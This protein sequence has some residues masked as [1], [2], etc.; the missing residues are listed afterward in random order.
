MTYRFIDRHKDRWPVRLLCAALDVSPA[1]YYAWRRCPRSAGRQ[2]H[3]VAYPGGQHEIPR[4]GRL[5]VDLFL[6]VL[7]DGKQRQ[8]SSRQQKET[9]RLKYTCERKFHANPFSL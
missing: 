1:G 5:A 9:Y 6:I 3:I 4:L 7:C 2:R 8:A